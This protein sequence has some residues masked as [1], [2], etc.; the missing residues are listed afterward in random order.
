M[1]SKPECLNPD[2]EVLRGLVCRLWARWLKDGLACLQAPLLLV[3]AQFAVVQVH[4]LA[5]AGMRKTVSRM[6]GLNHG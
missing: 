1:T 2:H 6:K 5:G 3:G 4:P